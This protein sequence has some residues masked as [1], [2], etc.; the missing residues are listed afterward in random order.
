MHM[1]IKIP[2]YGFQALLQEPPKGAI[3]QAFSEVI[4]AKVNAFHRQ[5]PGYAATRLV[6]LKGLAETWGLDRIFV[7]DESTRFN[8][9]AFKVLGGSYAVA[10]LVSKKLGLRLEETD[11]QYLVSDEAHQKIGRMTFAAAT[12]GNH[13]RGLA[14]AAQQLGQEAII[15]LLWIMQG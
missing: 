9:K 7:K 3:P 6:A 15:I 10:R 2:Q 8:L 11:Y 1:L 13:G 14:W 5:L 12:D 4:A